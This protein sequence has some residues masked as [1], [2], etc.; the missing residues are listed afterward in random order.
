MACHERQIDRVGL[1]GTTD[2][3]PSPKLVQQQLHRSAADRNKMR[4]AT[5]AFYE[6]W[7]HLRGNTV[8]IA[9]LGRL[10]VLKTSSFNVELAYASFLGR[11]RNE[12]PDPPRRF[13]SVYNDPSRSLRQHYAGKWKWAK[14]VIGCNNTSG[15]ECLWKHEPRKHTDASPHKFRFRYECVSD[16]VYLWSI[17][18]NILASASPLTNRFMLSHVVSDKIRDPMKSLRTRGLKLAIHARRGDSCDKIRHTEGTPGMWSGGRNCWSTDVYRFKIE[19]FIEMYGRPQ[20]MILASDSGQFIKDMIQTNYSF[21]LV[22]LDHDNSRSDTRV[23]VERNM[24]LN[25]DDVVGA[26]AEAELM[27]FGNAFIGTMVSL[28]SRFMYQ[29]MIARTGLLAPFMSIDRYPFCCNTD[30]KLSE[31]ACAKLNLSVATCLMH[32]RNKN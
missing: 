28:S 24:R 31:V 25:H 26:A 20:L 23:W 11:D 7:I 14:L 19:Q 9:S 8:D 12:G 32:G 4:R 1:L 10:A 29:K 2:F 3:L 27:S 18:T 5:D 13:H 15:V 17:F 30:P 22:Y 21:P 16:Q 6:T